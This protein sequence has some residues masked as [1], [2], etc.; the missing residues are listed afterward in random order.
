MWG[1]HFCPPIVTL[2]FDQKKVKSGGLECPPLKQLRRL[3]RP[4][5]ASSRNGS[6]GI[7][8]QAIGYERTPT[9]VI[10]AVMSQTNRTSVGS[11][12]NTLRT[13]NKLQQFC[14]RYGAA[15]DVDAIPR[16]RC[17]CRNMRNALRRL[18][19]PCVVPYI[20]SH[21]ATLSRNSAGVPPALTWTARS[22]VTQRYAQGTKCSGLSSLP[23]KLLSFACVRYRRTRSRCLLPP[24]PGTSSSARS[25]F[26]S[27][28]YI[29]P[30]PRLRLAGR[31]PVRLRS[32]ARPVR[33]LPLL[34]QRYST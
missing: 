33:T 12:R 1:G 7:T 20:A 24:P 28:S 19:S 34:P 9:T 16:F 14:G 15:P 32:P 22:V 21:S 26:C 8:I 27:K 13:R 29:S 3:L 30:A 11:N 10:T 23:D 6:S 5:G 18:E 25:R 17:A 4:A 2:V 31:R